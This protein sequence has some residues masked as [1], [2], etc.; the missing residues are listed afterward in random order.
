MLHNLQEF[1][2]RSQIDATYLLSK[3]EVVVPG[4]TR[5][6][7]CPECKCQRAGMQLPISAES[8]FKLEKEKEHRASSDSLEEQMQSVVNLAGIQG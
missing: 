3:K 5:A 7:P 8:S 4:W 1:R 2:E 6:K